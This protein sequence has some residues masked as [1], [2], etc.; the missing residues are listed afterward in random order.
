M[1]LYLN[2]RVSCVL[3]CD[4][5]IGVL[6]GCRLDNRAIGIQFMAGQRILLLQQHPRR[7]WGSPNL[8]LQGCRRSFPWAS[9]SLCAIRIIHHY[10]EQSLRMRGAI[11]LFPPVSLRGPYRYNFNFFVRETNKTGEDNVASC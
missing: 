4:S 2:V 9:S 6:V 1:C 8:I 5:A 10:L 3:L 11:R 7:L